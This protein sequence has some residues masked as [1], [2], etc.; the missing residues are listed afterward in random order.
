[1]IARDQL[2]LT[3]V[4]ENAENFRTQE[5]GF[6]QMMRRKIGAYKRKVDVKNHILKELTN[7]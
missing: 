7:N 1:M 3:T 4:K 5:D 6:D 2:E